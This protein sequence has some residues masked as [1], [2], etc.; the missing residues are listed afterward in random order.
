MLPWNGHHEP[1]ASQGCRGPLGHPSSDPDHPTDDVDALTLDAGPA[2][3]CRVVGEHGQTV[4]HGVDRYPPHED[5]RG[6][7][8]GIKAF[9]QALLVAHS[10]SDAPSSPTSIPPAPEAPRWARHSAGAK[11]PKCAVDR[12]SGNSQ[13]RRPSMRHATSVCSPTG[14]ERPDKRHGW[15]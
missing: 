9:T 8:D 13:F 7:T 15:K 10:P 1:L 12:A 4:L 11:L 14:A 3:I 2:R 5:F 6:A